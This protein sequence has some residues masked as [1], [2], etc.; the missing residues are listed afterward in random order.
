MDSSDMQLI[1]GIQRSDIEAFEELFK[2]YYVYLCLISEHIVRNSYDAEEVVSDVFI[3][4][5]KIRKR[6]DITTSLKSY[7][8]KAVRN[9]SLNYCE[10]NKI[11]NMMSVSLD[12]SDKRLLA[13]ESD[14]PLG[15]IYEQEIISM[16]GRGIESLPE[17]CRKIF[18]LSRD[19]NMKYSEISETLGI[20]VNTV[21]A[22]MRI[23][24][25]RLREALKYYLILFVFLL[26]D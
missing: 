15:K 4:L 8:A 9:T 7:L 20:S 26:I 18:L 1:D 16:L 24:L 14:Y 6:V 12:A 25:Y 2:R 3:K 21:K 17:A 13:W 11:H 19:K 22:Q 10:Q 23:A 5:W